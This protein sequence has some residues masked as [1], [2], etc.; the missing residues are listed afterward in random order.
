MS[1]DRLV[2]TDV[3]TWQAPR[4]DLLNLCPDCRAKLEAADALPKT[5]LG[6]D[7]CNVSQGL[8]RGFCACPAHAARVAEVA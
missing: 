4:G 1:D 3:V 8:H 5:Q 6:E 2:L 7:Y